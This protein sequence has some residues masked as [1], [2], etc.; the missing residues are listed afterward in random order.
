[1]SIPARCAAVTSPIEWPATRSDGRRAVAGWNSATFD[2][3]QRRPAQPRRREVT[4]AHLAGMLTLDDACVL[5]A[6]RGD[7]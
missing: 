3:E 7:A 6:P 1:V 5:V 2:G 4:A